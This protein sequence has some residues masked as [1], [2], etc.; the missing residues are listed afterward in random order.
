[1]ND[2]KKAIR[3]DGSL[4]LISDG[5]IGWN[6]GEDE[7]TLDSKFTI[8]QL[9]YIIAHMKSTTVK[10]DAITKTLIIEHCEDCSYVQNSDS[11]GSLFECGISDREVEKEDGDSYHPIPKWCPLED[12][13]V[14]GE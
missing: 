6:V 13:T 8:A 12:L 2:L 3:E 10:K 7:I 5:Y 14:V 11:F 9:E 1:M 4:Y